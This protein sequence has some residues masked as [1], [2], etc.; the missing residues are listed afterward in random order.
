MKKDDI[1]TGGPTMFSCTDFVSQ[2]WGMYYRGT[3][4]NAGRVV[5]TLLL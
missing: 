5:K 2:R 3:W 4:A 1:A